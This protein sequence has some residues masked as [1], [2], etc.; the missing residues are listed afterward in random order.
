MA[1]ATT[2]EFDVVVQMPG[3]MTAQGWFPQAKARLRKMLES[4]CAPADFRRFRDANQIALG[5]L[6][7]E[8]PSW[9]KIIEQDMLAGEQGKLV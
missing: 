7:R 6:K 3:D 9:G 2:A 5:R 4:K 8:L 1:A